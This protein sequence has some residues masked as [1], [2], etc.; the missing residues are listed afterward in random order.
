MG[1]SGAEGKRGSAKG[2]LWLKNREPAF[3]LLAYV[4]SWDEDQGTNEPRSL[5]CNIQGWKRKYGLEEGL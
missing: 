4:M 3:K 1:G 5:Q 2:Y